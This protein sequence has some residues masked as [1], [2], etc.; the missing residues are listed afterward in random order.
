MLP[1]IAEPK[2]DCKETRAEAKENVDKNANYDKSRVEQI[3]QKL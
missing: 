2:V 3:G 1:I